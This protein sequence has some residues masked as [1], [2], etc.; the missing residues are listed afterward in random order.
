M[1]IGRAYRDEPYI[2]ELAKRIKEFRA[3]L[4][5]LVARIRAYQ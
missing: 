1:F 2:A 5:A 3:D 4:D